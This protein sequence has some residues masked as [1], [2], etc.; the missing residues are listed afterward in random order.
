MK[1]CI[2][3]GTFN[4]IHLAHLIVAETVKDEIKADKMLLIPS[5]T[6]PHKNNDIADA[7]HRMEMVKLAVAD[8]SKI[9]VSDVEFQNSGRSYS[10]LTIKK[11]YELYPDITGRINFVIGTDAF[12]KIETWY[13]AEK[14]VQ[15]VNFV[16][17]TR[18]K[19]Y[20][21]KSLFE[22]INIQGLQAEV[23]NVPYSDISSSEIRSRVKLGKSIKYYVPNLVES[24]IELQNLYRV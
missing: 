12:E 11:L 6:P 23:V 22:S 5:F 24:Y 20:D 14:L 4:P 13:E 21:F 19:N 15:L 2:F 1:L 9:E 16:V 7:V 10:Y 18:D 8:N 3:S 17:V